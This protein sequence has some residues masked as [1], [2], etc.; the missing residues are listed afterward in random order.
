MVLYRMHDKNIS[1]TKKHQMHFMLLEMNET[2]L[3]DLKISFSP[4]ELAVHTNFLVFNHQ[5]F[6]NHSDMKELERWLLKVYTHLKNDG[7]LNSRIIARILLRRWFVICFNTKNFNHIIFSPL[8]LHFK[9]KYMK[10]FT[11]KIRDSY[12]KKNL[13]I[14]Y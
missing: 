8:L 6:Q 2:I 11:E 10:Y 12:L 5:F 3:N 13:G 1:A 9:W 14:D 4:R 7:R